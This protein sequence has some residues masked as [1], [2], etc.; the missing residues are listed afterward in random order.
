MCL[1][2][3][4]SIG[5]TK[6]TDIKTINGKKFYIHKVEK[7]QSLY[8]I[9]KAYNIDVNSVLAENDE[10]I[11]G[12]KP[13]QELKIPFE[14]LLPKQS[15]TSID[16]NMYVYHKIVKGE[17]IYGITKK[18]NIDEKKLAG[19]NPTISGGLK[20]GEYV[21]VGEKKKNIQV[22]ALTSTPTLSS[23]TY[24][25][26]Q[27]ETLYGISKKYNVSQDDL[28]KWNPEAKD[29]IKQG[30]V[31]KVSTPKRT[32]TNQLTV[33]TATNNIITT[34]TTSIRKAKKVAYNVGLFLP[35]KLSE[36]E[37]I[38]IDEL[39]KAKAS[40]PQAQSLSVD[41]YIGFKKAVDSLISKDF[42]VNIEIYDTDDRD[43]LKIENICKT[44]DFKNLDVIFGPLYSSVFKI[45]SKYAKENSIPIVSP[46]LQHNKILFNNVYSSKVTPSI[47]SIIENLADYS[48]DS[49]SDN[50]IIIVNTASVKDFQYVKSFK[51]KYN[52]GLLL[53]NKTMK[54]SVIEVKGIAGVKD[55]YMS[56]K[57]NIVVLLTNS[58]VYLQDFIT[59]LFMFSNKKDISLMGFS[60]VTNL[61]NLDQEYLNL[62]NFHF[63]E[64]S[65]LNY[66]DSLTRELTKHYQDLNMADP[67]E[68]YFE[69]YDIANYYLSHLKSQ[70]PD[71]FL[72][73]DKYDWNGV[74]TD[75][76]FYRPDNETGFENKATTIYKY[77]NYQLQKIGWK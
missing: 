16:T 42:D 2:S 56:G 6:S 41:F 10:A 12:I 55:A 40:F 58:Q 20:E 48:L 21:I 25:V 8:A 64:T 34:D 63:A 70:G 9:A 29:G 24:T 3:F 59:Q 77:S 62:L 23:D 37:S 60:S 43:S 1:L 75:F 45:V 73:L 11:D 76:K 54:D 53:H 33:L 28:L 31:L 66:K 22:S 57:K 14:S 32:I 61:D 30:Q 15:S 7:G 26:Q 47:Y 71:F 36:S 65:H 17:T 74:S 69:G 38:N 18:F 44:S 50:R 52:G 5:Q 49:L 4:V 46:V 27:S 35:F 51:N 67:S 39:A 68:K 72:N 13:G 19:Y